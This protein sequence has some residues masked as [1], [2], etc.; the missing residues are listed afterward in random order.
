MQSY[1]QRIREIVRR[2]RARW[3]RER[4]AHCVIRA[5]IAGSAVIGLALIAARLAGRSPLALLLIGLTAV[6]AG[7]AAAVWGLLPLRRVPSDA[8]VARFVEEHV[9]E[10]DDRLVTAVDV[11]AAKR[12]IPPALL[13][14]MLADA[15]RRAEAIDLD[16]VVASDVLRRVT[17]QAAASLLLLASLFVVS[18]GPARGAW[19]AAALT[20]FP[21]RVSLEV[22]PGNARVVA[23]HALAIE[24]R[25][26][27]NR[28][29]V[30]PQVQIADGHGWKPADMATT[31]PGRFHAEVPSV[32]APFKYRVVA[33]AVA[34][35]VYAVEV[36]RA[37]N[38]TRIDVE[39]TYPAGL[40]LPP[41]TEEDGGDI[42]APA[43]TDVRVKI[44][45]DRPAASGAMKLG[46]GQAIALSA[47]APT[48]LS[49]TLKVV[50]DNSYRV[51]LADRD[52]LASAGDTE[53]FIR[54]LQDRPPQVH[55]TRP[56]T[57]RSVTRLAEVDVEAEADDDYGVASMDLVYSVRGGPEKALPFPVPAK[58]TNVTG[59]RTLYLEDLGVAPGDFVSY[60]VRARDL[61]RG[62]RSSEARSDI[63]FLEVRPF[64]QEFALAQSQSMAGSGFNG[65]I[66]D[67]VNAQ[68]QVVVATWKL[69][70]RAKS[71]NAQSQ[72]DAHSVA[73]TE[74]DLKTRVESTSSSFNQSAMR[75]PR[76][77]RGGRAPGEPPPGQALPEED[78]MAAAAEAMGQ[79]VTSLDR[80]DTSNALPPELEAL[81]H[82]LKAQAQVKQRQVAQQQA[83]AGGPGNNNRNYDVSTLFDK[84]LQ[85][86]QQTNYENPTSAEQRQS[87]QDDALDKIRELARRQDELLHRQGDLA[88]QRGEMSAEELKRQLEKLTRDQSELRQR[89]EDLARQMARKGQVGQE[90]Q[91]GKEGQEGQEGQEGRAG[92]TGQAGETSQ[93]GQTSQAG[94]ALR[95]A[96]R[97]MQ[98]AASGLRRQDSKE[99]SA[100]GSRALDRLKQLE[101]QLEQTQPDARRRALGEMQLES[102]QL[103]D[104]ERQVASELSKLGQ[105]QSSRDALRRLAGEQQRLAD[106]AK[107]LQQGL[108]QAAATP[109]AG[110]QNGDDA[111]N[112]RASASDAARD[113]QRQKT[114]ERMQQAADQ[115]QAASAGGGAKDGEAKK[116]DAKNGER[117]GANPGD[118]RRQAEA[119]QQAARSL[120]AVADKLGAAVG[121]RDGESQK[122]SER[123]ARAQQLRD[124]LNRLGQNL[125]R[126][127]QQAQ[128][129]NSAQKGS[130]PG[131]KP[132]DQTGAQAAGRST[133]EQGRAGQGQGGGGGGSG[134]DLAQLREQYAR[135]MRETQQLVDQLRREDP[136]FAQSGEG[137]TFEG[138]GMT[139][140]APGTEAF[141]QDFAQWDALRRE[142]TRALESVESSISAKLRE[143]QAQDRL[144][145][146]VDDTPPAGYRQQ[147]DSYFKALAT[148]KKP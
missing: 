122:L 111:K 95:E 21:S 143:R 83:G 42:Y 97:Q 88:K 46:D 14:P 144:A 148:K 8:Q 33:G 69:D 133:G 6:V 7:L 145:A 16:R 116:G 22:S 117:S 103:A 2:A 124:D 94:E 112:A 1:E 67:L 11:L 129:D 27:G 146:G 136:S 57:D 99:A 31:A 41:R 50:D 130:T 147:V 20:L 127:G 120:D 85:R 32:S 104:A 4:V 65:S 76:K 23:G 86:Q 70:R 30:V 105:G 12:E 38:V 142:A 18:R 123:M 131:A 75:D 134:V 135:K 113:M 80:T 139:L 51:A 26:A 29:P 81:N 82:L 45:T 98:N 47:D 59:R 37:P 17:I 128:A 13:E 10:L 39:Y 53:Y 40:R 90:G 72:Q 102:R 137:F 141:K 108:D 93:A 28:A 54:T 109:G 61:T 49:G 118:L 74:A 43:G 121:D 3:R 71:A 106:R 68:K 92:Q 140:S 56:G 34:S 84:E 125:Q 9:P 60:Y 55:I 62:K 58:A 119:Q 115:L 91:E 5:A 66:D 114:A 25:L 36:A 15:A 48:V 24:A 77:P 19:D 110:G 101:R 35:P 73:R 132:G 44:H 89:V 52:G 78:S 63:F 138:Q 64:E 96:S 107:R 126:A 87:Q 79:A 100:S